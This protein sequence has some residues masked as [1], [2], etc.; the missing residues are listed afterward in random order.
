LERKKGSGDQERSQK[1][2]S[3][4]QTIN[5]FRKKKKK[6]GKEQKHSAW[7]GIIATSNL[8]HHKLSSSEQSKARNKAQEKKGRGVRSPNQH[9]PLNSQ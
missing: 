7:R 5:R 2:R 3:G 1:S 8:I 4:K 9:T 6:K